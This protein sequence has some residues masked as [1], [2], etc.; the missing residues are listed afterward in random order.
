M[1]VYYDVSS[2]DDARIRKRYWCNVNTGLRLMDQLSSWIF[3]EVSSKSMVS[4]PSVLEKHCCVKSWSSRS[5]PLV[6]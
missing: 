2:C 1:I 4:T 3:D 6:E 5:G